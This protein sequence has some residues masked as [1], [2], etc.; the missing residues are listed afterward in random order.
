MGKYIVTGATGYI[1]TN[2]VKRLVDNGEEVYIIVRETSNLELL[3][4]IKDR[5][6]IFIFD[7]NIQG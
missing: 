7:G 5:V 4:S 2:I 1:G 3:E 6:N